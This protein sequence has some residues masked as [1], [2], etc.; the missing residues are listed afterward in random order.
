MSYYNSIEGLEK[1]YNA[2]LILAICTAFAFIPFLNIFAFIAIIVAT[3][4][5]LMG[6]YKVSQDIGT[7]SIA[8]YITILKTVFSLF[9]RSSDS[10]RLAIFSSILNLIV[11]LCINLPLAKELHN[12]NEDSTARFG[13]ILAILYVVQF[14][15]STA[16]YIHPLLTLL[17][18]IILMIG[19]IMFYGRSREAFS[20]MQANLPAIDS[21]SYEGQ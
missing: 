14:V 13:N 12:R 9:T 18:S 8:F 16:L 7:V 15:T 5:Y 10:I 4:Y 19:Q 20:R 6:I 21:C 1:M 3:V 17:L 2:M 11:I